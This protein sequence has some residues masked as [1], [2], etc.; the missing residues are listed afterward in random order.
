MANARRFTDIRLDYQ[1]DDGAR[2]PRVLLEWIDE[3]GAAQ[4]A[5]F[6]GHSANRLIEDLLRHTS[7]GEQSRKDYLYGLVRG[8]SLERGAD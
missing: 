5:T 6:Y 8:L 4:A 3:V 2:I 1:T 7:A